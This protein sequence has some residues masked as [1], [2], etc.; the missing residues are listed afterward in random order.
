MNNKPRPTSLLATLLAF[1]LIA[2][3]PAGAGWDPRKEE[4]SNSE[5]SGSRATDTA[6]ANLKASDPGIQIFFDK[7]HGYAVFP[8]VGKA[9][10]FL[11][12]A[13]GEGEVYEKGRFIGTSTLTQVTIGLQLGGQAYT[14]IVFFKD[15]HALDNFTSGNFE[16]GAQASAIA[17]T[18]G[19]SADAGYDNGVAI[20]TLPKK[21]LMYEATIA[22]QKFSFD[23]K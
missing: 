12:G 22:G 14:E 1:T 3:G 11:G 2:A 4:S 9:G 13:Y 7:A 8:T 23:P 15:Q 16:L 21:G 5:R 6:I 20:F 10:M 18:A 19:V 17:L